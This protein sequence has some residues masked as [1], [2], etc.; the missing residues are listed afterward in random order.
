MSESSDHFVVRV[1]PAP[2]APRRGARLLAAVTACAMI[3]LVPALRA[4]AQGYDPLEAPKRMTVPPGF[5]VQTVAAEPLVRQPVAIEFDDAGRL[6]VIQY[7]QYPN[8]AGLKRAKVDRYS[9]TT[10]DRVPEPPPRGPKGADR[11]SILE[12]TNGDGRADRAHDFV[13]DLNLASG[14]AFGHGGVFVLQVPYLLFYADRN[15][16][17]L[18]DGDP[19]VL[20]TGFGM[21]DAHS[22]AN[23][24]TWGPDGWLYGCQGS[25][26]T[27]NIRGLEF[28]QGVWRYHPVSRRF[29]LFCEGG[30]NSWGLD[31]DARG[32][33]FYSTNYGGY[34]MLHG[35]Q[36]A[37]YWKQFGKHGALHNPHA[38]GYFDHVPHEQLRGGH[39]TVGGVIYQG[40]LFPPQ[41]RGKYIAADLLGHA[42]YWHA[43]LPRGSTFSARQEGDLLVANDTW[44]APSDVTIGPDGAVYVCDWH[45]ARTAHPDP[46]AE[47]DRANGRIYRIAPIAPAKQTRGAPAARSSQPIASLSRDQLIGR[48]TDANDWYVRRA[49][50]LLAERRDS[51]MVSQLQD[52]VDRADGPLALQALWTL[53]GGNALEE[54][55]ARSWLVHENAD[56]RRW[57]VRLLG[58]REHVSNDTARE[59][60]RLAVGEPAVAVR[61]QLACTAKRLPPKQALPVIR[62]LIAHPE[63]AADP[64]VPLLVWWAV[65]RHALVARDEMLTT[66]A[67]PEAW[68]LP[69]AR[70]AVTARLLRRYAAE[71]TRAGYLACA[72]LL[73][74]APQDQQSR[75]LAALDQGLADRGTSRG[76]RA[77]TLFA[78]LAAS[79]DATGAGSAAAP[80]AVPPTVGPPTVGPPEEIPPELAAAIDHHWRDDTQDMT[81]LRLAARLGRP[82]ALARATALAADE[83]L[84]AEQ[85]GAA[86]GLLAE[87][88]A[89]E[90]VELLLRLVRGPGTEVVREQA[91][92]ALAAF[93]DERIAPA[94][95]AAYSEADGALRRRMVDALLGRNAWAAALL[96]AVDEGRIA[97]KDI[98][99]EQLRV[100]AHHQ[101]AALDALVNKHWGRIA[102]GTPEERLAEMRRIQNDLRAAPG[103]LA[104]GKPL[105]TK[106]C[107]TCHRLHGEGNQVGP[108]LTHANRKNSDELLNTIV[109]PSAVVRREYLSFLVHTTEGRVLTGLLV[110]Q[111]L[112]SVTLL[113]AKNQR[114]TVPRERIEVMTESPT[115][116]MPDNLLATL[117]PQELRDLFAYLQSD[118]PGAK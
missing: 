49:R 87:L 111:S 90:S 114:T 31:F 1:G 5:T 107:G 113:D 17:D 83:Q 42:M 54:D 89:A 69:L 62:A 44:F 4:A 77:G 48:L 116:L 55:D 91:L 8:P 40:D 38:Y 63:D 26:V 39:V 72:R 6:W 79:P 2:F 28:Q 67:G 99:V 92:T 20:L 117:R 59:L 115:S 71:G 70:D 50:R 68:A 82:A 19:E 23:S 7:L 86:I 33:L 66:F 58:D 75:M 22:V 105:F 84:P 27:A 14:L 25:T 101:D 3:V 94:L 100:V 76:G 106:H 10:Y 57:A 96:A 45:D 60:A 9:R 37:Y 34:A 52:L 112:G 47:W 65:E 73:A 35:V 95:L 109:N 24:L 46:D 53:A 97:A 103:D 110:D 108:E 30:G 78:D 85:R 51:A 29:E 88:R 102:A 16:D 41:F 12:D 56:V 13:S 36:G 32:E 15:G 80:A 21:D 64:Y 93:E 98:A 18:P 118:P 11:I 61:A 74:A 81:V 43:L 104:A